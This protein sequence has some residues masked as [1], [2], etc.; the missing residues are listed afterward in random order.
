MKR[1]LLPCL[2]LALAAAMAET[3]RAETD[4]YLDVRVGN[5]RHYPYPGRRHYPD[6]YQPY[7]QIR[8]WVE[9]L[10]DRWYQYDRWWRNQSSYYKSRSRMIHDYGSQLRSHMRRYPSWEACSQMESFFR[11]YFDP[12][13]YSYGDSGYRDPYNGGGWSDDYSYYPDNYYYDNT[14]RRQYYGDRYYYD[15]YDRE[16]EV[17]SY[18]AGHGIND[19]VRGSNRGDNLEVWA[20]SLNTVGNILGMVSNERERNS[21]Y[22][23]YYNF[24]RY[25]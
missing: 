3:A 17:Y 4:F 14:P 10:N 21:S 11:R 6:R 1:L 24:G 7:N 5:Q 23:N 20:G 9:Y 13:A 8:Q 16:S 18:G 22:G 15:R 25:R 2:A 12:Y 19:I